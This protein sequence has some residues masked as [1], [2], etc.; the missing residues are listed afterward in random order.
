MA[1]RRACIKYVNFNSLVQRRRDEIL[2]RGVERGTFGIAHW[3]FMSTITWVTGCRHFVVS[4][5]RV[6]SLQWHNIIFQQGWHS[7]ILQVANNKVDLNFL[8]GLVIYE[9][10]NLY[11]Y[12]LYMFLQ[13]CI[14]H[15][16]RIQVLVSIFFYFNQ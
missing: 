1:T 7:T 6:S 13:N 8:L 12:I 11:S 14:N 9:C 10:N 2:W 3:I 5:T 16:S 4:M 15:W